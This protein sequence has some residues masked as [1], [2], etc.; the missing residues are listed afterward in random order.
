MVVPCCMVYSQ[1]ERAVISRPVWHACTS[2]FTPGLTVAHTL[3]FISLKLV[4]ESTTSLLS[5]HNQACDA[6]IIIFLKWL[7]NFILLMPIVKLYK[8]I[9]MSKA[10]YIHINTF[11]CSWCSPG[12]LM[13]HAFQ[14]SNSSSFAL[15][16]RSSFFSLKTSL[17][18]ISSDDKSH[19]I[20]EA[21]FNSI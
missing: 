13:P 15:L 12:L 19:Q 16:S 1:E 6:F 18:Q 8:F 4:Q 7:K 14:Y 2:G 20:I 10:L 17:L 5:F 21:V 3:S 9:K 11:K